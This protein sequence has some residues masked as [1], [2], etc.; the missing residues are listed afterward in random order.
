MDKYK[1]FVDSIIYRN[2]ENGYTVFCL[3]CEDEDVTCVGCIPSISEGEMLEITGEAVEHSV[4]GQQIKVNRIEPITPEDPESLKRYLG[5]GAI[6]GVGESLANRIVKAFGEDTLRILEEEPERLSE[7]KGIS[8]RK[9]R[10]IA[11]QFKEKSHARSAFIFLQGYG[12]SNN[13]AIRIYDEYGDSIYSIMKENPYRLAEDIRGIGFKMAD[14]I[15]TRAG[16]EVDSQYRIKSGIMYVLL[17]TASEGHIYVPANI[18]IS[19]AAS[20]LDL[21]E[22]GIRVELDNLAMERKIMVKSSGDEEQ[23][24]IYAYHY[25]YAE[26]QCATMLRDLNIHI[27]GQ[28]S[29]IEQKKIHNNI[30]LIEKNL[31]VDLDELQKK[32]VYEAATNGVFILSGG[33]GTG[34]TTTINAMIS[35]FIDEGLD[36]MLAAP[37]GRAAKRMTE[38]TGYEAKTIHRMLELNGVPEDEHARARFERNEDNPLE[39][40]VIIIDEMSM[41]DTFLFQALLKAIVPGTRLILVGDVDQL[42]SVGPG[43]VLKDLIDSQAFP[44]I[45]LEKIFRQASGSDIVTNA[46]KIRTGDMPVL[47]NKSSDFF[48]LRRED[49]AVVYKHMVQLITE[50]LP[51]YVDADPYDIQVLTPMRK[52]KL[53]VEE[54]NIILQGFLNPADDAKK[55]IEHSGITFREGDKVM[56]I[57]NNYQLEWVITGKYNI[58]IETGTGVFNGDMGRIQDINEYSRMVTVQYDESKLV[59]YTFNQLEE[60]ELAYAVTIHKSQGSEYPAVVMPLL[61]GPRQLFNRNLLYTGVTRAKKCVT[62]LGMETTIQ[63]MVDNNQTNVRYTGLKRRIQ[64]VV[65]E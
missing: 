4:Y 1:G 22:E 57:K 53:G 40:D 26:L 28:L 46:H 13:M 21:P 10:E 2:E 19:R 50:K 65:F 31:K 15:A 27:A 41:V 20:L 64:E 49:V 8:E 38:A 16:I 30:A 51:S 29:D 25:Y 36:V 54:L 55:E 24:Q 39:V 60:L 34:K 32:A 61:T 9:A 7:V 14:E 18:L 62:I 12:I 3:V 48:F 42:P 44:V 6:K 17:E 45:V 35:Y 63:E 47:D 23:P 58:P 33:P 5:S 37:T 43:Q 56:Q 11:I 52:G 59:E